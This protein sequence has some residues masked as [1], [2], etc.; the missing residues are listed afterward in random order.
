MARDG[1]GNLNTDEYKPKLAI[2]LKRINRIEFS[3]H[4]GG[5]IYMASNFQLHEEVLWN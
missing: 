1:K 4:S 5:Y 2:T 3:L